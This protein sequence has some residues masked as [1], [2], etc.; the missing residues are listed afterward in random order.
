MCKALTVWRGYAD[1]LRALN[2]QSLQVTA[3]RAALAFEAFFRRVSAGDTPGYPRFKALARFS[4]WGY[5]TYGDGW[6]L[7]RRFDCRGERY[8]AL[9]L[10]GIGRLR[11]RGKGRFSGM[12]KTCEIVYK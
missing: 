6:K 3:R 4:G 10:A 8:E 11:L 2:A 7:C 5:K 12:P 1:S 9:T